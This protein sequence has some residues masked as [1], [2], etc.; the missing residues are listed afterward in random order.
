MGLPMHNDR[1]GMVVRGRSVSKLWIPSPLSRSLFGF[2]MKK[3]P[4]SEGTFI[5]LE[6]KAPGRHCHPGVLA[7]D[8]NL[9]NP[10]SRCG[11]C[12]AVIVGTDPSKN[13]HFGIVRFTRRKVILEAPAIIIIIGFDQSVSSGTGNRGYIIASFCIEVN[14]FN[15]HRGCNFT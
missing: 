5:A 9:T 6:I 11:D 14:R 7:T 13:G 2:V 8:V 12:T 3:S 4:Q 15:T 1:R 10:H